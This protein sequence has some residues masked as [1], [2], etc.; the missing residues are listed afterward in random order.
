MLLLSDTSLTPIF[1]IRPPMGPSIS[2]YFALDAE[3]SVWF[4]RGVRARKQEHGGVRESHSRI[5]EHANPVLRIAIEQVA[6]HVGM[7]R[8]LNGEAVAAVPADRVADDAGGGGAQHLDAIPS[9][10]LDDIRSWNLV[11]RAD[12]TD[13]HRRTTENENVA[14]L[15]FQKSSAVAAPSLRRVS[16][17]PHVVACENREKEGL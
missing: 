13:V 11:V 2:A 16:R 4:R 12:D 9:I 6:R 10:V 1:P 14:C 8:L 5:A 7:R 3:R 17:E 15:I